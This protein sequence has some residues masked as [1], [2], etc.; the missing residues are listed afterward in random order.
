MLLFMKLVKT[1]KF[2]VDRKQLNMFTYKEGKGV[3][4]EGQNMGIVIVRMKSN[5]ARK[6]QNQIVD[7]EVLVDMLGLDFFKRI[8]KC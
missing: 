2:K 5:E 8:G 4:V 3:V 6:S 7:Y 1:K